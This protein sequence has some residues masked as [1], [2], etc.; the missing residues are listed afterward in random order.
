MKETD[1]DILISGQTHEAK[2][3]KIDKRYFINP[4]SITG[5]Y[6]PLA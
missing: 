3:S 2:L 4:G 5:S 1:A 6:G